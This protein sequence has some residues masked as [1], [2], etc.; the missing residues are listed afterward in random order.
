MMKMPRP[1]IVLPVRSV[2]IDHG[3][4]IMPLPTMGSASK[5]PMRMPISSGLFASTISMPTVISET[6]MQKIMA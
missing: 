3:R 6:V 5:M 1:R 4:R 2:I